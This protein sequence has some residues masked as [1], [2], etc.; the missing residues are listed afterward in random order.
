M[1]ACL[2]YDIPAR[3]QEAVLSWGGDAVS[4]SGT[5]SYSLGQVADEHF[6]SESGYGN[7]GVQQPIGSDSTT[8]Y[9][10]V[11]SGMHFSISP[12]P[13]MEEVSVYPNSVM[14]FEFTYSIIDLT[15]RIIASG[16]ITTL[17][18]AIHPPLWQEGMYIMIL[19]KDQVFIDAIKLIKAE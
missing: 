14:E 7:E 10:D 18:H 16:I 3:C 19:R 11:S 1:L 8:A 13:F 15:G 17:R 4:A 2:L 9:V 6:S 5:V 12:N